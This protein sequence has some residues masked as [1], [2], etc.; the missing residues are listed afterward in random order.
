MPFNLHRADHWI[1]KPMKKKSR[2]SKE[3]YT[4]YFKNNISVTT[5]GNFSTRALKFCI[6]EIGADRCLYAIGEDLGVIPS[7]WT[8]FC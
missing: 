1:N 5:S 6:N 3:D 8:Y 4:Y 2:P 7:I